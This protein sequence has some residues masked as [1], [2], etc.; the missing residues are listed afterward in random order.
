MKRCLSL[1]M[2]ILLFTLTIEETK[3]QVVVRDSVRIGRIPLNRMRPQFDKTK[4][5]PSILQND[6]VS[7]FVM[8]RN[9]VLQIYYALITRLDF[10][11]PAYANLLMWFDQNGDSVITDPLL[12]RFPDV[13]SGPFTYFNGCFSSFETHDLIFYQN[14]SAPPNVYLY[15]VGRV[16]QGDTVQFFYD[17]QSLFTG[18]RD[19]LAILL[20]DEVLLSDGTLAGWNVA[21]GEYDFCLDE[22]NDRLDVFIGV[23]TDS[24]SID[25]S[26]PEEIWPTLFVDQGS[27]NVKNPITVTLTQNNQPL[28][29]QNVTVTARIILPSSPPGGHDHTNQPLVD[30]LGVFTDLNTTATDTGMITTSTDANGRIQLSYR[31]PSFGGQIELTAQAIITGSVI[32]PDTVIARDALAVRVPGLAQLPADANNYVKVGGTNDHHGPPLF[33]QEM[34]DH[35]HWGEQ[36]AIDSLEQIAIAW[37]QG[38]PQELILHINDISLACGGLFDVSGMWRSPHQDHRI[39]RDVD[40][41]T[42]LPGLRQGIP[43]RI[44]RNA[45]NWQTT[46][47]IENADFEDICDER[48]ARARIHRRNTEEEHYHISF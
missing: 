4:R 24:I 2:M 18:A 40:L 3:A 1:G 30:S 23:L 16:A 12:P 17:T 32:N 5:Y 38:F 37:R 8:P 42:E 25:I 11:L 44:P 28:A 48:G 45:V 39:G 41:R 35:N 14:F 9:G 36:A 22:W 46:V 19:T 6:V 20:A 13:D 34:D 43:V 29:N 15:E 27:N 26:D 7:G 33:Q 21:F 31:A 10:P 47:L